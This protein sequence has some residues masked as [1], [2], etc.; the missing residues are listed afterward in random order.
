M[1]VSSVYIILGFNVWANYTGVPGAAYLA[2]QEVALTELLSNYGHIDR[3]WWCVR[4]ED[5]R[6]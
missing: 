1:R 5:D 6:R 2:Q 4:D 3:L